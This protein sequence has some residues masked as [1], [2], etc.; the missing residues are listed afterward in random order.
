M[1]FSRMRAAIRDISATLSRDKFAVDLDERK[2]P[3]VNGS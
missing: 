3:I 2:K 1:F